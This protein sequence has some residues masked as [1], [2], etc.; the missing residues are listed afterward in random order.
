M[1]EN[2]C[3][4]T[5]EEVKKTP[6]IHDPKGNNEMTN[7]QITIKPLPP[8][9]FDLSAN[10]FSHGD[11]QIRSYAK[12]KFTQLIRIN[13]KLIHV[14]AESKGTVDKPKLQMCLKANEKLTEMEKKK[15][16]EAISSLFNLNLDVAQFYEDVK[17]D[18]TMTKITQKLWGLRIPTT[19]TVYEALVDSIVEQQISIKVAKA[20]EAKIIKKFGGTLHMDGEVYYEYP[21]PQT[22]ASAPIEELRQCGLSQRKAEYI[23]GVSKLVADQKLDLEKYKKY[24]SADQIIKEMDEIRG[25]GV[26]TAELTMLRSMNMWDAL[27]ADDFG[28]RRVISHYYCDAK[29]IN[30]VQAREIAE[31]WGKWKGLAAF[32]L[33]VAETLAIEV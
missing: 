16:S 28:I 25:I 19:Q 18:S 2:F 27:P 29:K 9:S 22:I 23:Q 7:E 6:T 26:W 32:Y 15:S 21:T 24:S 12:G 4:A 1:S 8:F 5:P 17:Q 30:S 14:T 3:S 13:S 31:A 20:L 10:I 33:M 11:G